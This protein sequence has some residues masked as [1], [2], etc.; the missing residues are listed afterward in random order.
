[1]MNI[2]IVALCLT[3]AGSVGGYWFSENFFG[4]LKQKMK[5][6]KKELSA[7]INDFDKRWTKVKSNIYEIRN[8]FMQK[9]VAA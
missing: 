1:M 4:F 2:K 3:T 6:V 5:I 7:R 8:A 9:P